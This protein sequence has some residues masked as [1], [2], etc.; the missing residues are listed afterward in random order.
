[1]PADAATQ[2]EFPTEKPIRGF[3]RPLGQIFAERGISKEDAEYLLGTPTINHDPFELRNM[4]EAVE[5]IQQAIA[6][7]RKIAIY[8]D[9]DADG[10]TASTILVRAFRTIGIEARPYIPDRGTEGYGL[11][12]DALKKLGEEGIGCVVSVDCGISSVEDAAARPKDMLLA[13]TDHHLP[14]KNPD[15]TDRI[16]GAQAVVN[17]KQQLDNYPFEGLAGAGVALKLVQALEKAEVLPEGTSHSLYQWAAIGTVADVMPLVDENRSIVSNG[18]NRMHDPTT[19]SVGLT[20]LMDAMKINSSQYRRTKVSSRDIAWSLGP[21]LNAAGRMTTADIALR[22]CLTENPVEATELAR[23]LVQLND[24]RKK[25]VLQCLGEAYKQADAQMRPVSLDGKRVGKPANAIVIGSPAWPAGIVGLIAGRVAEKYQRPAMAFSF[26]GKESKGSARSANGVQIVDAMRDANKS[27]KSLIRF[28]G[29]SLAA[30]CTLDTSKFAQFRKA[31]NS[32]V[33]KQMK[34]REIVRNYPIDCVVKTKEVNQDLCDL[35]WKLEPT[36]AG[37][38]SPL[39]AVRNVELVSLNATG[40][41]GRNWKMKVRGEDGAE[42]DLVA[43]NRPYLE[44]DLGLLDNNPSAEP[45][46]F[47]VAFQMQKS[48]FKFRRNGTPE[49]DLILEAVRP[50]VPVTLQKTDVSAPAARVKRLSVRG[51][52]AMGELAA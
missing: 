22:L 23:D 43:W 27:T 14:A 20:A 16:A 33:G 37:L 29:H 12:G 31:L 18:L 34:G 21:A 51:K 6:E 39:L 26:E 19:V 3:P 28:G 10:I 36:G 40:N 46:K 49:Y 52:T 7:D 13:I 35:L 2:W 25:L 44:K 47:D 24:E 5:T 15:G 8:G 48:S 30:G 9:Y 50:A 4:K 45:K 17:P 38:R 41:T 11:H 42:I 32:A 1:M